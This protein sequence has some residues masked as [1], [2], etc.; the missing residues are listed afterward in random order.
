MLSRFR[1]SKGVIDFLGTGGPPLGG[2]AFDD[3][4][5][6]SIRGS[7]GVE[8]GLLCPLLSVKTAES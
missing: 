4:P 1:L 8:I 5:L 3:D 2:A 7:C 6:R